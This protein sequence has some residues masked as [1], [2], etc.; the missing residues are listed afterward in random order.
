MSPRSNLRLMKFIKIDQNLE[1]CQKLEKLHFQHCKPSFMMPV[2]NML[3]LTSN[4]IK[5]EVKTF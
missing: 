5:A 3:Q 1:Q 4:E 2:F